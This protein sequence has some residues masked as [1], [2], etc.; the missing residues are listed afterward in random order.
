MKMPY[1]ERLQLLNWST[2]TARRKYLLIYF[3]TKSLCKQIISDTV[4]QNVL[5]YTRLIDDLKSH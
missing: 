4:I 3:I 2:L 5:V 1:S